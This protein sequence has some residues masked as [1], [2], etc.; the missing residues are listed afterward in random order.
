VEDITG[1]VRSLPF[2]WVQGCPEQVFYEAREAYR[3]PGRHY[4]TWAHVEDCID[5]LRVMP[6]EAPR[7]VFLALVFHDAVY[8][9][10]RK[11]NE[12]LSADLADDVLREHTAI[13]EAERNAIRKI[14]LATRNHVPEPGAGRDLGTALDVDMS[15]LGADRESYD[16]YV[17]GVR[18]EYVPAAATEAEFK[19]GRAA[20]LTKLLTTRA[21]FTTD[22]GK[23]RWQAAARANV[24]LEL[25]ELTQ[26][27]TLG[28]R[29][30][31]WLAARRG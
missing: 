16:A 25:A 8:V 17:A 28:Q 11:D 22:E 14:V 5:K 13:P 19:A 18:R 20:F 21:M 3:S 24:A 10:G 29:F 15:I 1:W 4:H 23:M 27:E 7:T 31:R 26:H 12:A 9:P 30:R 6:V 2:E